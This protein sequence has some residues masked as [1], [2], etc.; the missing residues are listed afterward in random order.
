MWNLK[1][2]QT[3]ESNEKQQTHKYREQTSD[4]Q[5][6]EGSGVVRGVED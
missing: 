4:Y 6:G 1:T 2:K 3:S 5:W